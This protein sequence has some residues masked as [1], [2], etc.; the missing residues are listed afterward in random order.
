MIRRLLHNRGGFTYLAALIIVV[1]MGIMLGMVG[2]TWQMIMRRDK[3]A[4]LMFRGKQIKTAIERYNSQNNGQPTVGGLKGLNI[5]CEGDDRFAGR[6]RYLRKNWKDPITDKDWEVIRHP[7]RGVSGVNSPS[8]QEPL[9]KKDFP[10]EYKA[11]EGKTK[12]KDWKFEYNPQQGVVS[13]V[14]PA[15]AVP[16]PLG[17]Q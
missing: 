13:Q 11:F 4:E 12:Y 8:E 14:A 5:L 3:E 15:Q 10:E 16:N 6:K 7:T 17:R 9:K 1:I 2:E